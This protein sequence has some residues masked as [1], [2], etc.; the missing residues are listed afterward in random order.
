MQEKNAEKP[1]HFDEMVE[2]DRKLS[3][4]FPFIR[5]DFF[6]TDEQVYVAELTFAP[7]GGATPYHPLSFNKQ[8]GDMFVLPK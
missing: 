4:D 6:D 8:L 5:V 2:I 3:K 1:K 7:G